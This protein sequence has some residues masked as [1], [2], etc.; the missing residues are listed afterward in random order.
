MLHLDQGDCV[1]GATVS[2]PASRPTWPMSA[3]RTAA[4]GWCSCAYA[5]ATRTPVARGSRADPAARRR[6]RRRRPGAATR[7]GAAH[8][9]RRPARRAAVAY[10]GVGTT[11]RRAGRRLRHAAGAARPRHRGPYTRVG[12]DL[13][14]AAADRAL[15][16]G[17][18]LARQAAAPDRL[19]PALLERLFHSGRYLL[20]SASG[21]CRP[22]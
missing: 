17:E 12:L 11:A 22:G 18:L 21:C 2:C 9:A 3:P 19:D 7:T 20:F 15:P 6:D 8:H 1:V 4:T 10:P 13:G 14:V 5:P 16:V